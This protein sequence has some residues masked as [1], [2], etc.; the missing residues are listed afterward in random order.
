[1]SCGVGH[2]CGSDPM[3]LWLWCRL[4]AVAPT[5]PLAWEPP[6]AV[7]AALKTP[8]KKNREH[9]NVITQARKKKNYRSHHMIN[10][11]DYQFYQYSL[12]HTLI[13]LF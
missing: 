11:K 2:R 10:M 1:M 5:A 12:P 6:Y 8:K 9:K 13:K 3:L 4:A 7:G